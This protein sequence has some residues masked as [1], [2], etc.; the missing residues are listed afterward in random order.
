MSG[1]AEK[2]MV[3]SSGVWTEVFIHRHQFIGR[4]T[5]PLQAASLHALSGFV[6]ARV[7]SVLTVFICWLIS[8]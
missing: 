3:C 6:V 5:V 4:R 2:Q 1:I 8:V 7:A